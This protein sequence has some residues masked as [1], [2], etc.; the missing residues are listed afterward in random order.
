MHDYVFSLFQSG[1]EFN[2]SC[3]F[4]VTSLT[5]LSKYMSL[6]CQNGVQL[7]VTG[8]D[9]YDYLDKHIQER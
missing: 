5:I 3:D 2:K 1:G 6:F 8:F 7:V 4:K 9:L